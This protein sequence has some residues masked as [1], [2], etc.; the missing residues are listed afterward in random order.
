MEK[1]TRS[2]ELRAMRAALPESPPPPPSGATV[3]EWFAGLALANPEL[4]RNIPPERRAAEAV[5]LADELIGAMSV[6]R[7]PSLESMSAPSEEELA[8]WEKS[9]ADKKEAAARQSKATCPEGLKAVKGPASKKPTIQFGAILPPPSFIPSPPKSPV[10][11]RDGLP[12]D[13]RYSLRC[14]DVKTERP[15]AGKHLKLD[16]E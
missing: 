16:N 13:T 7:T 10:I 8:A 12:E 4:M 9:I 3:R 1:R 6:Q 14:G 2:M 15:A 11:R 5:R